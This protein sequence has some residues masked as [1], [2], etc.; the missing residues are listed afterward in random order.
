MK[1]PEFMMLLLL[2]PVVFLLG[3]ANEATPREAQQFGT[4][5]SVTLSVN[6]KRY[7]IKGPI[8][9][10]AGIYALCGY[11]DGETKAL[12]IPRKYNT[13]SRFKDGVASVSKDN[14]F[15]LINEQ[16]RYVVPP[17]YDRIGSPRF[18]LIPAFLNGRVGVINTDGIVVVPFV[19]LDAFPISKD[20]VIVKPNLNPNSKAKARL[21]GAYAMIPRGGSG[22]YRIGH[23]IVIQDGYE[24]KTFDSKGR[25]LVLAREA[26][27]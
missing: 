27:W 8:P 15:G 22:L 5:H 1:S 24:F 11:I 23:G 26:L 6:A 13:A 3:V 25:G 19:Y 18:G 7:V 20:A 4:T 16:G 17:K 2:V 9:S 12:L 10:C 14:K 21:P